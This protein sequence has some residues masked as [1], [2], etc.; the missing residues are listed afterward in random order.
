M[1]ILKNFFIASFLMTQ[2]KSIAVINKITGAL[3]LIFVPSMVRVGGVPSLKVPASSSLQV[4]V[5][6]RPG[7]TDAAI[8]VKRV[9]KNLFLLD[10]ET[11]FLLLEDYFDTVDASL[12]VL[13]V[14]TSEGVVSYLIGAEG[15]L[16]AA[17]AEGAAAAALLPAGGAV[18]ALIPGVGPLAG[19]AALLAA[20]AG[21]GGGGGGG[22]NNNDG[23]GTQ[24]Q[25]IVDAAQ[26]N[27]AS[28]TTP[29][30]AIYDSTGVTG[31]TDS[32]L[33]SLNSALNTFSVNGEAVDTPAKLQAL[34]DAYNKILAAADG[35]A[36][37]SLEGSRPTADDF[38]K[39]GVTGVSSPEEARLLADVVDGK[40]IADVDRVD[41]IQ[42]LAN[43]VKAVLAT[44][45]GDANA[46]E[47]TE[48]QLKLMGI[49]GVTS[50]NWP[51]VIAAVKDSDVE[52]V[53]TFEELQDLVHNLD[54]AFDAV[55]NA[56]Q[57]NNAT[58]QTPSVQDYAK[59]GV[60]GVTQANLASLNSALNTELVT[61]NR[62]NSQEELQALVDAYN[63]ILAAADGQ[64]SSAADAG[65][66]PTQEDYAK[67]GVQ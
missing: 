25:G 50:A 41:E 8:K 55:R 46:D 6:A 67:V 32:N 31:V 14:E 16:V 49:Q 23:G 22:N 39:I 9:G 64:A 18:G 66:L 51:D 42:A 2:T 5:L 61:G 7:A 40:N 54:P 34:I 13:T 56:A 26:N 48:L 4:Q 3:E 21:G 62:V 63:K 27:T 60:T 57:D 11:E 53:D 24:I 35:T 58:T 10:E 28:D 65:K 43:A 36:G 20:A 47:P 1:A 38:A 15:Q 45:R 12:D 52:D 30:K 19:L 33:A 17:A 37:N 29:S 59:T 44:A